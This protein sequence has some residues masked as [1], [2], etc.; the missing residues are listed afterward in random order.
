MTYNIPLE[1]YE[2][3]EEVVGKEKAK[4]IVKSLETSIKEAFEEN[5]EHTKEEVSKQLKE[6]LATKYDIKLSESNLENKLLNL[7]N[8]IESVKKDMKI[9]NIIMIAIIILLNQ[10]SI[11]Y[12]A[13]LLGLIK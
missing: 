6:E 9:Q 5:T 12:I 7:D 3:F 8:K 10:N 11:Q 1:V 4:I 2:N 13:K